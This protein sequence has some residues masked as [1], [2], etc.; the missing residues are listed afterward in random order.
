MA[1]DKE[2]KIVYSTQFQQ[3]GSVRQKDWCIHLVCLQGEGFFTYG[4]RPFHVKKYDAVVINA[5]RQVNVVG[6]SEDLQVEVLAAPL[7][8]LSNQ[9][10]ANN[11]GIGWGISL[12]DNPIISLSEEEAE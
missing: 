5:P 2:L 10:P 9:L 6:Q 7:D 3:I 4:G 8:F 11:Y 1:K 12:Y